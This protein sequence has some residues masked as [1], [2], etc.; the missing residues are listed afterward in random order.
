LPDF[1]VPEMVP[2]DD[3]L[4]RSTDVELYDLVNQSLVLHQQIYETKRQIIQASALDL[5]S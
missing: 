4:L 2:I 3:S 5:E 1:K